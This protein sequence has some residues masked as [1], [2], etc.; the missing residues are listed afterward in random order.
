MSDMSIDRIE[1]LLNANREAGRKLKERLQRY[2]K[3]HD[4]AKAGQAR[5][6]KIAAAQRKTAK[7]AGD[8]V[9]RAGADRVIE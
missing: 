7:E 3:A 4:K 1:F 5:P 6:D 8:V 2:G 9:L